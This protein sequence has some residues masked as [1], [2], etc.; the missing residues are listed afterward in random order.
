VDAWKY[1]REGVMEEDALEMARRKM[2]KNASQRAR[3]CRNGGK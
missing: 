1:L 3:A 2:G